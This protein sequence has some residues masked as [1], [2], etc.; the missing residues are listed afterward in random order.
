MTPAGTEIPPVLE[1]KELSKRFREREAVRSLSFQ[2]TRGEVFG[3]LGPNGAGKTTTIG[4][5][6]GVLRPTSGSIRILGAEAVATGRSVLRNLGLVP[7]TVALY[8]ALTAEENLRFFG[9]LYGISG[10]RLDA[11]VRSLLDIAGL[12]ARGS[13]P[14]CDFSGGMKRRLNL[15]CALVHEPALLLLDEPTAGVDPQSRERIYESLKALAAD[16]LALLLTTHYLEEAERLC[17]RI[18]ILDE[19]RVAAEGTVAELRAL[20]GEEP[21]VVIVLARPPGAELAAKL[22]ERAAI[23]EDPGRFHLQGAG[24]ERLLPEI[25]ALAAAEGN[26]VEELLLH[27][28][29][30]GDVFLRL[31]GKALRD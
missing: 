18:A 9:N 28:P 3:L 16:G 13:G 26:E 15:V 10:G 5:I 23:S 7:Q 24:A 30:L 21:T 22:A 17:G 27:R 19:G 31:T 1:V 14:V 20:A 6:A 12:T 2:I 25:L 4:M 11:R 8:P 29:N